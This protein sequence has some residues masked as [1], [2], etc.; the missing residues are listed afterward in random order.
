M[1]LRML[2]ILIAACMLMGCTGGAAQVTLPT[3]TTSLPSLPAANPAT[4]VDTAIEPLAVDDGSFSISTADGLAL[5]FSS[6][7]HILGLEVDGAELFDG[8]TPAIWLRDMSEAADPKN[9]N[10]LPNYSF[11]NESGWNTLLAREVDVEFTSDQ[12]HD[13]KKALALTASG[14]GIGAVAAEPIPVYPGQRYRVSAYFLSQKGYVSH[15]SGPAVFWQ[16]DLYHK[17]CYA[18]GIYLW[19]MDAGG[20]RIGEVPDLAAAIHWNDGVW[21]QLT[22]EVIAPENVS[23]VEVIVA[24]RPDEGDTIWV[25]DV[26]LVKSPEEDQPVVGK[27]TL[28]GKELVQRASLPKSELEFTATYSAYTGYITVNIQVTDTSEEERALEVAWGVPVEMRGEGNWRWWDDLRSARIIEGSLNYSNAV[29]AEFSAWMPMS[30]YPAAA[31]ED[32]NQGLAL[33]LPLDQPRV[34]LLSFDGAAERLEGR[35]FLGIS[36]E[37]EHLGPQADFTLYFYRS[38]PAWGLRSALARMEEFHPE[39]FDARIIPEEYSGFEQGTYTG[40]SAARKVAEYDQEGIYAPHYTCADMVAKMG[41][42]DGPAPTIDE[43][44]EHVATFAADENLLHSAKAE[45]YPIS[46]AYDANGDPI[47]KHIGVF[48]WA[49]NIWEIAWVSNLDPDLP[50]GLGQ[51]LL[52]GEVDRAFAETAAVGGQLDGIQI[53]NFMTTPALDLRTEH[54]AVAD[55]PLSYSCNDYRPG[56]HTMGST[57]E[58]LA[59]LRTHLDDNYGVDKG[60]SINFW[61]LATVNFL[62]PWIDGFGGEGKVR[63]DPINWNQM[64]LDYRRAT[65]GQRLQLFAVQETGLG[66]ADINATGERALFYG[67][68]LSPGRHGTGWAAGAEKELDRYA[69]LVRSYNGQGWEPLTYARTDNADVMVERFGKDVFTVY[70]WGDEPVVYTLRVNLRALGLGAPSIVSELTSGED[71]SFI[72]EGDELI[73]QDTLDSGKTHVFQVGTGD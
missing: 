71:A 36:S 1:M 25:D 24:G 22:R 28:E 68:L 40:K 5:K 15:P 6:E 21:R 43:G 13:G 33:A 46:V 53:D 66:V 73:F 9:K 44:W 42:A 67:I 39:W 54:I 2:S 23:A 8:S 7:G 26:A 41:P 38:D 48:S 45:T 17:P 65:A 49:P 61:G 18:T 63:N 59:S 30:L 31:I 11:E 72:I 32:E 20:R 34:A 64:V 3:Q 56:V 57:A 51:Y 16:H 27:M 47:L 60:I 50:D 69:E 10:L 70:N 52:K 12:A 14:R 29:S 19:W 4:A 37:A 55:I 58:Y 35:A 62:A